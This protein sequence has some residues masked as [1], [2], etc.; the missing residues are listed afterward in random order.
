[1]PETLNRVAHRTLQL[2]QLAPG[3]S[4]AFSPNLYSYLK[5][6]GHFFRDGGTLEGVYVVRPNTKAASGYGAGTLM[7]GI[8]DGD[9]VTGTRLVS[10]LCHGAAAD[11]FAFPIGRS[12]DPVEEFWDGYLALGRCAIDPLHTQHFLDDRFSIDGDIR[13]CLW[14]GVKH[15]RVLTPRTVFDESWIVA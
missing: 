11:R 9:F 1:M 4:A 10:A 12:V 5:A 2:S 6:H 13:T 14:C 7:L 3:N 8:H 15:T